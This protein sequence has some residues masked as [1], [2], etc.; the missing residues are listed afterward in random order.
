MAEMIMHG[1]LLLAAG[2][3]GGHGTA[4]AV[5]TTMAELGFAD[6]PD[7]AMTSA[8]VGILAG[9]FGGLIFIKW[10]TA[11]GYTQYIKNFA[12]LS[13]DLKTGMV[14]R[15][16]QEE[17]GRDTVSSIALDP[18]CWHLSILMVPTGLGYLC[19]KLVKS[20]FAVNIP[21][22]A[23]A[24]ILALLFFCVAGGR[25]DRGVY[26]YIDKRVNTRISGTYRLSGVFRSS[27][28]QDTDYCKIRRPSFVLD[29]FGHFHCLVYTSYPGTGHEPRQL[30]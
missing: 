6:A 20:Y 23:C 21:N 22:Y 14:S 12:Y 17:M 10:A 11:K 24:F 1:G 3:L 28:Y 26:R 7:L 19:S 5:G 4:A 29:D 13:G 15:E 16:N 30:V 18:L 9:V 2:F 25:T 8:T 27:E